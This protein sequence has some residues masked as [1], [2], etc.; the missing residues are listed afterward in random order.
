MVKCTEFHE[1]SSDIMKHSWLPRDTVLM[2]LGYSKKIA[3]ISFFFC[4][5][6]NYILLF[7]G[8][9]CLGELIFQHFSYFY[10]EQ[11]SFVLS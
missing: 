11:Y 6:G 7:N 2:N 9:Y 10:W 5:H 3:I 4:K 8:L 1:K